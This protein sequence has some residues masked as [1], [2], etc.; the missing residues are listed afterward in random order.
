M[1]RIEICY[2]YSKEDGAF[3]NTDYYQ[4][5]HIPWAKELLG[6]DEIIKDVTVE[7]GIPM[8]EEAPEYGCKG[9]LYVEDLGGFFGRMAEAAPKFQ[10]DLPNFTNI[11]PPRTFIYQVAKPAVQEKAEAAPGTGAEIFRTFQIG[12]VVP[13]I[14]KAIDNYAK[15]FGM[16]REAFIIADSRDSNFTDTKYYGKPVEF[17]LKYAMVNWHGMQFEVIEPL[18]KDREN[19]YTRFLNETG[20]VGGLHHICVSYK[21][22]DSMLSFYEEEQVPISNSLCVMGAPVYFFDLRKETGLM[23]ETLNLPDSYADVILGS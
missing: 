2:P 15:Y 18:E 12:C 3:F 14:E 13:D 7:I 5:T 20:G 1:Y 21:D 22:F 4:N 16:K 11:L 6:G 17:S 10:A 23:V 9:I 19:E 8:G